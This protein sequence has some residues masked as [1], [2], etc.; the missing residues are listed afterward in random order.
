MLRC[1]CR[2]STQAFDVVNFED[3]SLLF[4]P[5]LFDNC[6]TAGAPPPTYTGITSTSRQMS[7]VNRGGGVVNALINKLPVELHIPGYKFCGPG[8][9]LFERI[10][11]GDQGINP[12]DAA[13]K[14]HDIAYSQYKDL[15]QR[16]R[17]DKELERAAW[18]RLKASDSTFG[19]KAA[20]LTVGS[21]MKI[22]MK[23]GMGHKQAFRKAVVAPA[24]QALKRMRRKIE[25]GDVKDG[26]R[27]AL[28]AA[29]VAVK[30]LGGRRNVR[31]PR[32]IPIPKKG[33][34]LPLIPIFA[35]LSALGSLAGGAAAVAKAV[36]DSKVAQGQLNE[37]ERH[38]K[39][40]EA[41][42]LK[43]GKGLYLKPYRKG[44]GLYLKTKNL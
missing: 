28:N 10:A 2:W 44:L 21:A 14:V 23:F 18:G 42:Q 22:K 29:K 8:T 26:A 25:R 6:P 24:K 17:A 7:V 3:G 32:I 20:A 16:H 13:C 11:R 41:I 34:I 27:M 4:G 36:K 33:G 5:H 31:T 43:G 19:E 9:R 38:N 40:M 35:G 37:T 39:A 30:R 15:D 12:L 1:F